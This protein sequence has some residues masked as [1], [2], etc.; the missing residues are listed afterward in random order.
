MR[1]VFSPAL[2]RG[3]LEAVR[4]RLV[5]SLGLRL[6]SETS[7]CHIDVLDS[8]RCEYVQVTA[9]LR[10]GE[11]R[12]AEPGHRSS[13]SLA[14]VKCATLPSKQLFW[15]LA[16]PTTPSS[17]RHDD[18]CAQDVR[19]KLYTNKAATIASDPLCE[20]VA[21]AS[22]DLSPDSRFSVH[23][24]LPPRFPV[25]RAAARPACVDRR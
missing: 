18:E 6:V 5:H 20:A 25:R 17:S 2:T 1:A 24:D 10:G 23:L 21:T 15:S 19:V 4:D 7:V 14:L 12:F 11:I 8:W 3:T 22:W 9:E 16:R 13:G